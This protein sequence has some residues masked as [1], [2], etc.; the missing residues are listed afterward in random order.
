MIDEFFDYLS[1]GGSESFVSSKPQVWSPYQLFCFERS[2][3]W[4]PIFLFFNLANYDLSL[5]FGLSR[6]F[7]MY[8]FSIV[9]FLLLLKIWMESR[10]AFFLVGAKERPS[11]QLLDVLFKFFMF[12]ELR[13]FL[14]G[15]SVKSL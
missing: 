5:T 6:S 7:V 8:I 2:I 14:G 11:F 3:T 13:L 1:K 9:A 12:N 4:F 10:R 15:S